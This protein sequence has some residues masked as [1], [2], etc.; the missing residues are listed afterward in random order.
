MMTTGTVNAGIDARAGA[1]QL[2]STRGLRAAV[3]MPEL[4]LGAGAAWGHAF[5]ERADP[6]AGSTVKSPPSQVRVWFSEALEPAFS[7]LEVVSQAGDRVDRGP[8]N[9]DSASPALLQVPLKPLGP[10]TYRVKWRVLS[11]DTH[12]T[13]G[14]FT[15]R[16]TGTP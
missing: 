14:D 13:E 12:V 7:T 11:V 4:L 10:G 16:V 3:T 15:F 6:R 9:V 8:A 1:L 2:V 5:L